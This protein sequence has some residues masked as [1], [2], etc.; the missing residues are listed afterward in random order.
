MAGADWT[1]EIL[2]NSTT[3][4]GFDAIDSPGSVGKTDDLVRVVTADTTYY[5]KKYKRSHPPYS[6]RFEKKYILDEIDR[7]VYP[8]R[9]G[10]AEHEYRTLQYLSGLDLPPGVGCPRPVELFPRSHAFLMT[11]VEH[12]SNL[13]DE[14]FP[15]RVRSRTRHLV[16]PTDDALDV[17]SRV[18]DALIAFQRATLSG[19]RIDSAAYIDPHIDLV[20]RSSLSNQVTSLL[21]YIRDHTTPR[22]PV[23]QVHGEFGLRNV[24][25][26]PGTEVN[27][28]DWN[29]AISAHPLID[30]HTIVHNLMRWSYL[31]LSPG[32]RYRALARSLE[33]QY[34]LRNPFDLTLYD[35]LCTRLTFLIRTYWNF[36]DNSAGL[37]SIWDRHAIKPALLHEMAAVGHLIE[38][39]PARPSEIAPGRLNDQG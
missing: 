16:G 19:D 32:S 37:R 27:F 34:L 4:D 28:I 8:H 1:R 29:M 11:A 6:G 25:Y 23:V 39:P 9:W 3:I 35:L 17:L 22:Y 14:L 31:P 12:E 18:I 24:L 20:H 7:S 30:L 26:G 33:W 5:L 13:Y 38:S 15:F 21:T 36:V 10:G 2:R